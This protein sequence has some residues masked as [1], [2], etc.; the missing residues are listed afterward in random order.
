M[1]KTLEAQIAEAF[2]AFIKMG[3]PSLGYLCRQVVKDNIDELAYVS[4]LPYEAVEDL[5][6]LVKSSSQLECIEQ[7]SPQIVMEADK[8]WGRL[9]QT[10]HQVRHKRNVKQY[11]ADHGQESDMPVGS[12]RGLYKKYEQEQSKLFSRAQSNPTPRCCDVL[13]LFANALS[14]TEEIDRESLQKLSHDMAQHDKNKSDHRTRLLDPRKLPRIPGKTPRSFNTFSRV[15]SMPGPK[16][17]LQQ[18]KREAQEAARQRKMAKST[19]IGASGPRK[20]KIAP[21]GVVQEMRIRKQPE[22]VPKPPKPKPQPQPSP[23]DEKRARLEARLEAIKGSATSSN[24]K[25]SDSPPKPVDNTKPI[26]STTTTP[27]KPA[28]PKVKDTTNTLLF[29]KRNTVRVQPKLV[30]KTVMVPVKSANGT[31]AKPAQSQA[32]LSTP[33]SSQAT[34]ASPPS[35]GFS[36]LSPDKGRPRV[37]ADFPMQPAEGRSPAGS[38]PKRAVDSSDEAPAASGSAAIANMDGAW[39]PP[40]PQPPRKKK[41]TEANVFM[42]LKRR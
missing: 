29:P 3:V 27:Q 17:F 10:D 24:Q 25:A 21:R 8:L 2:L 22:F 36:P 34:S 11:K 14:P 15:G 20:L 28:A 32:A 18:A 33:S 4:T 6:V 16:T 5:L 13:D 37:Q 41:R 19:I 12:W 31:K 7:C 39:S 1:Q 23:E 42:N 9:V 38:P 40:G 26:T 30:T 35:R